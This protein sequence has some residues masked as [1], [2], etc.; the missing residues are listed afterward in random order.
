MQTEMASRTILA[1]LASVPGEGAQAVSLTQ[2]RMW[3]V[4][5]KGEHDHDYSINQNYFE[6][7][8]RQ[9]ISDLLASGY[10]NS[11]VPDGID[12][13]DPRMFSLTS[14]GAKYIEELAA[15]SVEQ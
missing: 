9:T 1:R 12:E 2:I 5:Q 10:I 14:K 6:A 4:P 11:S 13:G 8:L 3:V 15:A 7:L